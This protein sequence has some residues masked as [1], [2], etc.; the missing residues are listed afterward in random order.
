MYNYCNKQLDLC[1][2]TVYDRIF[3]AI[4]FTSTHGNDYIRSQG[5][6]TLPLK[7]ATTDEVTK[8]KFVHIMWTKFHDVV[9]KF[10]SRNQC[11]IHF[12]MNLIELLPMKMIEVDQLG[13]V[14]DQI[15]MYLLL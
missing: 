14:C 15:V 10:L 4:N 5:Q 12:L 3:N 9:G 2:Q 7:S 1:L 8:S 13:Q 6:E 11:V